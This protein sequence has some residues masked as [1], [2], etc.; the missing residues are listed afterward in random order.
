[1]QHEADQIL[2]VGAAA[3]GEGLGVAAHDLK[4]DRRQIGALKWVAVGQALVQEHARTPH[5]RWK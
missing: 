5:I 1:M 2:H 4:H 3:G